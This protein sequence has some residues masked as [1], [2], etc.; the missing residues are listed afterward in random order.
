[1]INFRIT[2][3]FNV[4]GIFWSWRK[5]CF[6]QKNISNIIIIKTFLFQTDTFFMYIIVHMTLKLFRSFISIHWQLQNKQKATCLLHRMMLF[7]YLSIYFIFWLFWLIFLTITSLTIKWLHIVNFL[8][9]LQF[10]CICMMLLC[11]NPWAT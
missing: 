3:C 4:S 6:W 7:I 8:S 11:V 9:A 1:M 2:L 5:I 10:A